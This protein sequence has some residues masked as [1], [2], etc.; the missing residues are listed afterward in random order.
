MTAESRR[1]LFRLGV[2]SLVF[3]TLAAASYG[4]LR[5]AFERRPV[6]IRVRWAPAVDDATRQ[7]LEQRHGLSRGE[8]AEGRTWAYY[9]TD[10][11]RANIRALVTE[12]AVEDTQNIHRTAFRVGYRVP[13]GPYPAG[14]PPVVLEFLTVVFLLFG[15]VA[16]VFDPISA[17]RRLARRLASWIR[18]RIPPASAESVALFRIVFG[19]GLLAI[20]QLTP[21]NASWVSDPANLI[22]PPQRFALRV[23][24][25]QPW[26]VGWIKPWLAFWGLLFVAGAFARPSF[27]MLTAGA[28]LW[29]SVYTTRI[30]SHTVSALLVTLLCLM[31]SRW[32]DAWSIDA[33][34]RRNRPLRPA[35]PDEYGYTIWLPGLAL[36]VVLLA[37]AVAK[38]R[39]SG[40]A[41]ILNGTVKYHF[42]S[43]SPQAP[44]DWGLQVGRYPS[45]AVALS[46][47]AIAVESLVIVGV[48]SRVYRH[49]VAAG[50]AA[51]LLLL[52]F[53]LMQGLVWPAWWILLLSFLPWHLVGPTVAPAIEGPPR[54]LA[55]A[56]VIVVFVAQ[57]IMVSTLRLEVPPVMSTYDMYATT[58]GSPEAYE[59]ASGLSY[60]LVGIDDTSEPHECVV[61]KSEADVIVQAASAPVDRETTSRLLE[62]C[63]A[64]APAIR[65]VSVESREVNV[66]WD[67]WRLQS[68]KRVALTEPLPADALR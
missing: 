52:G 39:E 6:S 13:R 29:A 66:D 32:G 68:D 47:A 64:Q 25:E 9:L 49:R 46:F 56:A 31:W 14:W 8:L 21:L 5:V 12:P 65:S 59:T 3:W 26:I 20:F 30:V 40:L 28:L 37:A 41:W 55:Y 7:G 36:G 27:V 38:L 51:A 57:Q 11:S 22:S 48:L 1:A 35:A 2:S 18:G 24:A 45:L 17:S 15:L 34:R 23:L 53:W 10:R 43:D 16:I 61:P 62:R 54:R 19:C 63:F 60:W 67:R 50:M 58:Y 42:L 4:L 33:S 44:V